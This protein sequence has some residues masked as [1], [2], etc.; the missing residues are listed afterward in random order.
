MSRMRSGCGALLLEREGRVPLE[1]ALG[2]REEPLFIQVSQAK[3]SL[4]QESM[5]VIAWL[6]TQPQIP[7]RSPRIDVQLLLSRL[8]RPGGGLGDLACQAGFDEPDSFRLSCS[9]AHRVTIP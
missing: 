4:C 5:L 3:T 9:P 2:D 6:W 1:Q 8:L 7:C